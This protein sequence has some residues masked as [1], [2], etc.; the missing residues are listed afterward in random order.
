[1]A[2]WRGLRLACHLTIRPVRAVI[3]RTIGWSHAMRRAQTHRELPLV[4]GSSSVAACS[5]RR[6]DA[7][8]VT[9]KPGLH[10]F[11]CGTGGVVVAE[12]KNAPVSHTGRVA[13]F[14]ILRVT[15]GCI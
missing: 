7:V 9:Q 4:D 2:L 14:S 5:P 15:K 3:A 1:M 11:F 6:L 8:T 12:G 13:P 10:S